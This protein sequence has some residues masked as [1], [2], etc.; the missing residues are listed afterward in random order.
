[1]GGDQGLK[2]VAHAGLEMRRQ[3]LSRQE[4]E[5]EHR[6]SVVSLTSRE[7]KCL[8]GGKDAETTEEKSRL[9]PRSGGKH[10][11]KEHSN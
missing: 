11:C 5:A 9:K 4:V 8:V 3:I 7:E 10:Q 6:M 2:G 1:M